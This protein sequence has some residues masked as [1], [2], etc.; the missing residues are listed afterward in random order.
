MIPDSYMEHI[1]GLTGSLKKEKMG[2]RSDE[3]QA[4][5]TKGSFASLLHLRQR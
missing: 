2:E 4:T 3:V 5:V 1:D